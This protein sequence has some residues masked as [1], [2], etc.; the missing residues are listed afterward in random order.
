MAIITTQLSSAS[1]CVHVPLTSAGETSLAIGP[2]FR[3]SAN[4]CFVTSDA[5]AE[6]SWPG[7]QKHIGLSVWAH[8]C[9][10]G[11]LWWGLRR[12]ARMCH[13]NDDVGSPR[14]FRRELPKVAWRAACRRTADVP[15]DTSSSAARTTMHCCRMRD[16]LS[17]KTPCTA[18]YH[19][20][21]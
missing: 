12:K 6:S 5:R 3:H 10:F 16:A 1:F 4:H 14:F 20:D 21:L 11:P 17:K 9:T 7:P 19:L 2:R 8:R 13:L 18:L 15:Q